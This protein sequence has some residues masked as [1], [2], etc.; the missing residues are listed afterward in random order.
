MRPMF[1]D[2]LTSCATELPLICLRT[3]S[4]L[5]PASCANATRDH[6]N[7]EAQPARI[8]P[9][10][11]LCPPTEQLD[12]PANNASTDSTGNHMVIVPCL[13]TRFRLHTRCPHTGLRL[14]GKFGLLSRCSL[15]SWFGL[16]TGPPRCGN[17]RCRSLACARLPHERRII[18]VITP[19]PHVLGQRAATGE[20]HAQQPFH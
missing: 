14:D 13:D 18:I 5:K 17:R 16:H 19:S 12:A 15:R 7:R 2:A 8:N 20:L 3:S 11:L 6:A 9:R 4:Y 10:Q 1:D